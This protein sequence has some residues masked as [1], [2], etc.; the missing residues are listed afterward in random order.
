MLYNYI[1]VDTSG[2]VKAIPSGYNVTELKKQS[3][4][5]IAAAETY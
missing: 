5:E 3:E 2:I 4:A 1:K